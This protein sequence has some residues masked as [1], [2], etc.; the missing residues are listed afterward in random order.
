M[1]PIFSFIVTEV[2]SKLD[3]LEHHLASEAGEHY[4]TVE[5]MIQYEVA[6]GIITRSPEPGEQPSGSR[7]LLRL[8]RALQF[9]TLFC[10][11]LAQAD[12][13]E[14]FSAIA[15]RAY[16]ATLATH[17]EWVLSS[18]VSAS[19]NALSTLSSFFRR[20]SPE[21]SDEQVVDQLNTAV[22]A[23]Q[24]VYDRIQTLYSDNGLLQLP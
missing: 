11:E 19:L 4:R 20:V 8:H 15:E 9:I 24:P 3:I 17:H 23:M 16:S 7:T 12:G 2:N 1:G 14:T 18:L 22:L 10:C 21:G 13:T 5:E 6:N